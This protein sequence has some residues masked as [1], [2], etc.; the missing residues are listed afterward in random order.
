MS[1]AG[2]A[3]T[4]IDKTATNTILAQ[5]T[6]KNKYNNKNRNKISRRNR[7]EMK[8]LGKYLDELRRNKSSPNSLQTEAEFETVFAEGGV[9]ISKHFTQ[10][11][12]CFY[13][14]GK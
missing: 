12:Q 5:G 3:V 11:V 13:I 9:T 1:S 4:S 7:G 8:L 6:T 2:G 14:I 10:L